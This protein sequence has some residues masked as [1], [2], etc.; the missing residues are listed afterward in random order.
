VLRLQFGTQDSA[1][2]PGQAQ[3][4][5]SRTSSQLVPT[6]A[7]V[8]LWQSSR[9]TPASLVQP[10]N[11]ASP[12]PPWECVTRRVKITH[13][14]SH[15]RRQE[16][17]Q[18]YLC[19]CGHPLRSTSSL[20]FHH[21]HLWPQPHPAMNRNLQAPGFRPRCQPSAN[22]TATWSSDKASPPKPTSSPHLP[23]VDLLAKRQQA[24]CSFSRPTATCGYF[25]N[26]DPLYCVSP[27]H[28]ATSGRYLGCCSARGCDVTPAV[29][30]TA[31]AGYLV[32]ASQTLA[33]PYTTCCSQIAHPF[34]VTAV[35][36]APAGATTSLLTFF[37]CG[38]NMFSG[39]QTLSDTPSGWDAGCTSTSTPYTTITTTV[40]HTCD[41]TETG[42]KTSPGAI[43]GGVVGGLA[44]LALIILAI[45][46]A[47]R[48]GR[49]SGQTQQPE[50]PYPLPL[51]AQQPYIAL[52]NPGQ[53]GMTY[54]QAPAPAPAPSQYAHQP[55]EQPVHPR[56][57]PAATATY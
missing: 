37:A 11:N 49:R 45:L 23:G 5:P 24:D 35:S 34:C 57:E 47:F 8:A 53:P 50:A 51:I 48:W 31:C 44:G 3:L 33:D 2:A 6:V 39:V 4:D 56:S 17:G 52:P 32:C 29:Y 1:P 18:Y 27:Y 9:H 16:D 19:T 42:I 22:Q 26:G 40:S 41:S 46:F 12:N 30:W 15:I 55:T 36:S 43:A 13:G 7:L 14:E 21:T 28:C 25:F 38:N 20:L 54:V 10:R